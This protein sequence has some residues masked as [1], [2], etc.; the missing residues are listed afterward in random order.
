MQM[1]GGAER[2]SVTDAGQK[3]HSRWQ[4]KAGYAGMGPCTTR[5]TG[6]GN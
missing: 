5:D 3:I 1:R 6:L 2:A 4:F